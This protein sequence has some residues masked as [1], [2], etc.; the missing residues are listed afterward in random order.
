M[1]L[2]LSVC[3]YLCVSITNRCSTKMAKWMGLIFG[4][5]ASFAYHTLCYKRIWVTP[6]IKVLPSGTLSKMLHFVKAAGL[7]ECRQ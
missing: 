2:C 6:K 4:M 3:V 5:E 7:A 1:A